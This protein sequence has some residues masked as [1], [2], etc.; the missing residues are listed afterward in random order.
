MKKGR[1]NYEK[2]TMTTEEMY[3][4][5]ERIGRSEIFDKIATAHSWLQSWVRLLAPKF[6]VY[7]LDKRHVFAI[8]MNR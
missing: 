4:Y 7:F 6:G 1:K 5:I 2:K 3:E 8:F